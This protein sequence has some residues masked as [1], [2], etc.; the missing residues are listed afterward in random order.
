MVEKRGF[1]VS[2]NGVLV[3]SYM[4]MSVPPAHEPIMILF[5]SA[6]PNESR[7]AGQTGISVAFLELSH[8]ALGQGVA[9]GLVQAECDTVCLSTFTVLTFPPIILTFSCMII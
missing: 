6:T 1:D 2:T 7:L 9:Q 5:Q 8:C 3:Y 4:S